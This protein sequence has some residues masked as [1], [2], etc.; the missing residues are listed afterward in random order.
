VTL[1]PRAQLLP[2]AHD[3]LAGRDRW[4]TPRRWNGGVRLG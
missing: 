4:A 2:R 3:V 1:A